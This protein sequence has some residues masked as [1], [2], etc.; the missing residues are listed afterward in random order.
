MMT[1]IA[2]WLVALPTA[3]LLLGVLFVPGALLLLAARVRGIAVI[4]F[5]PL[6]S[7]V[8]TSWLP[9]VLGFTG[10]RF[11]HVSF[12]IVTL[13]VAG[14]VFAL[15]RALSE[16]WPITRPFDR[17][18]WPILLGTALSAPIG[19]LAMMRA[20]VD[21]RRPIQTWDGVFHQN[22]VRYILETGNGSSTSIG[23]VSTTNMSP[24]FYPAGWHD[25]VSL[26]YTG[27]VVVATNTAALVFGCVLFPFAVAV[28]SSVLAKSVTIAPIIGA[29]AAS[30]FTSLPER[31]SSYGT[32]WPVMAGYVVL[33]LVLAALVQ[34][35]RKNSSPTIFFAAVALCGAAGVSLVHPSAVFALAVVGWWIPL[36]FI[37]Q[38]AQ[39]RNAPRF[40]RLAALAAVVGI[41]LVL[42]AA[43]LSPLFSRVVNWERT[44]YGELGREIFGVLSDSQLS[45]Q[46]F[47]D[48]VPEWGIVLGVVAGIVVAVLHR[49]TRWLLPAYAVSGYLYVASAVVT[50]PGY[51]WLAPW[52]YDP[53]RLGAIVPVVAAPLVAIGL[54][55]IVELITRALGT[56]WRPA[57][58]A[59][60]IVGLGLTTHGFN[61]NQGYWMLHLN[62]TFKN[63][64]GLNALI[65]PDE[66]E[67]QH[68]LA[69]KLPKGAKVVGDPRT[70]AALLYA[71]TGIYVYYPHLDG[72]WG[73]EGLTVGRTFNTI[74][75]NPQMCE[76]MG[77]LGIDYFYTDDRTY[78]PENDT[79]KSFTGLV[80]A[81]E[82]VDH[83]E[84]VDSGGGAA[85]YRLSVCDQHNN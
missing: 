81:K 46:G 35:C 64:D 9:V 71:T 74:A 60:A 68:R 85:L 48:P 40:Q 70:G 31:P 14:A 30:S 42:V 59:A 50:L 29:L 47:G 38:P 27:D 8:L 66:V 6:I 65:S 45:Q 17:P 43:W 36:L 41:P 75:S 3:L 20:I 57:V 77:K 39:W 28:L 78:W 63:E 32:L 37:V 82:L 10:I 13:I 44:A 18:A 5:A 19:A 51:G 69:A 7:L 22:A 84:L 61:F 11:G 80:K 54:T 4:V 25:V 34:M 83:F 56:S 79:S 12:W 73:E 53:V 1:I 24:R 67:F 72:S 58:A 49:H 26:G 62:Y 15:S 52:Y 33:P 23:A 2:N 55:G 21:P 76:I 16:R